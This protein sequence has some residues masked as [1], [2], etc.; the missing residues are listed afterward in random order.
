MDWGGVGGGLAT[1]LRV[2]V[3]AVLYFECFL[4]IS[5]EE[6]APPWRGQGRSP[7]KSLN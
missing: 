3:S 1:P 2:L 4:K 6:R 7:S 5:S